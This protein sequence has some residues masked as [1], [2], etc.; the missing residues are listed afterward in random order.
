[1]A[2]I[3]NYYGMTN[4]QEQPYTGRLVTWS[5]KEKQTVS[6]SVAAILLALSVGFQNETDGYGESAI[7]NTS[8]TALLD[9]NK[10]DGSTISLGGGKISAKSST[11]L[12]GDSE[13]AFGNNGDLTTG[14]LQYCNSDI[15]WSNDYLGMYG[16]QLDIIAYR[17]VGGKTY[18]QIINE[19]LPATLTDASEIVHISGMIN[20]IFSS[21]FTQGC[22]D[23]IE[24]MNAL[25]AGGKKLII[26][27]A[28]PPPHASGSSSY[29]FQSARVD[30]INQAIKKIVESYSIGVYVNSYEVLV[31]PS[32]T[33]KNPY[34]NF[35]NAT[36]GLHIIQQGAQARGYFKAKRILEKCNIT[37]FVSL[38][39]NLLPAFTG[40][41]GTFTNTSGTG[42]CTGTPPSGWTVDAA[43]GSPAITITN[44]TSNIIRFAITNVGVAGTVYIKPTSTAAILAALSVGRYVKAN[45]EFGISRVTNCAYGPIEI[46]RFNGTTPIHSSGAPDTINTDPTPIMSL[47]NF[48]GKRSSP[49]VKVPSS[50]SAIDIFFGV[51][52][53]AITG[54]ITFD[55]INPT[56]GVYA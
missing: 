14:A 56:F 29:R 30:A 41:G 39:S 35:L 48:G 25:V 22:L 46:V 6:D 24:L 26:H 18:R 37:S 42:S 34:A 2:K 38:Q 17:A 43:S 13:T 52:L 4:F 45:A 54:A 11:T 50:P 51:R 9:P 47:T 28:M 12:I 5:P 53:G 49:L 3:I 27:E 7:W 19:Q 20:D 40:T 8:G 16:A 33:L 31:D 23:L 36:D 32:S 15:L 1:M 55:L 21:T 44:P 10:T